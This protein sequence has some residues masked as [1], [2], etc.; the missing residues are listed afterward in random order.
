MIDWN[1]IEQTALS[2]YEEGLRQT[3]QSPVN[4]AEGDVLVHTRMVCDA[5]KRLP[6]YKELNQRQQHIVYVAALLHDIGKIHTTKFIDGDWHTPHHAPTG[7]NMAR[8]LLWRE[9]GLCGSKELMEIREAICLLIRYHSFPPVAI[10]RENPQL[11][12][13]RMAANG[14]LVQDFSIRLLCMLCKADMLGRNCDDQQEVLDKVA[15]CEEL[16]KEEGC[17]DGCYLFPSS[18]TQRAFLAGSD[19]WKDQELYDDCWDEVVL[20]SGLPGTGKDIWIKQN[21][22][23]LPM[24][25]L[26]DIRRINKIPP[27]AK[28]GK[29]ANIAREQAKEY[30]RR[31]QP[32]V[33]NATNITAQMRETLI[34]LFET[35]HA[36]VRI[37]YLETDWQVL[38][39]RNRSRKDAVPQLV[40]EEMMGKMTL[41]ETCEAR[42][43]EWLVV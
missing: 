9:Y 7:S 12:L 40:I 11:R 1:N 21:M 34:S 38:L 25:S 15:L 33:W 35:Y 30:L 5:L 29:V 32:F 19:V 3:P 31:Q 10:E 2:R 17:Y 16:A 28:Q 18:Y 37:V 6:E 4:H 13:H 20:M 41:P 39:E 23:D 43:V 8:E 26:D 42:N 27:T 36:H 14:L 22:P 24:I